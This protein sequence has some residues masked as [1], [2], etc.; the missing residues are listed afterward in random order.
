MLPPAWRWG[1]FG[2]PVHGLPTYRSLGSA[3]PCSRTQT[4]LLSVFQP[5]PIW[6]RHALGPLGELNHHLLPPLLLPV[7]SP[8]PLSSFSIRQTLPKPPSHSNMNQG[9]PERRVEVSAR[10]SRST[11]RLFALDLARNMRAR[12]APPGR[13]AKSPKTLGRGTSSPPPPPSPGEGLTVG[14][15]GTKQR[16]V[17]EF[18]KCP[19]LL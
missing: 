16:S 13:D 11:Y 15:G 3:A 19:W 9:C 6:L 14:S 10:L 2:P 8:K 18:A 4:P 17:S 12:L 5:A 1:S 7:P